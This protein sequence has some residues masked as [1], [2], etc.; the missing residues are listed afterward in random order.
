MVEKEKFDPVEKL[1]TDQTVVF[2]TPLEDEASVYVRTGITKNNSLL[3]SILCA[4]F[5]DYLCMKKSQRKLLVEKTI[6][7]IYNLSKDQWLN[8]DCTLLKKYSTVYLYNIKKSLD[9]KQ[10]DEDVI[11][12]NILENLIISKQICNIFFNIVDIKNL[13]IEINSAKTNLEFKTNFKS[14]INGVLKLCNELKLI[15]SDKTEYIVKQLNNFIDIFLETME[16]LVYSVFLDK[17]KNKIITSDNLTDVSKHFSLNII[18]LDSETRMPNKD[19]YVID[20]K[21]DDYIVL[22]KFEN[23]NTYETLGE[24]L[25]GYITIRTFDNTKDF[26]SKIKNSL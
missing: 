1:T 13:L 21:Y 25:P 15:N 22:I 20:E 14:K 5:S 6:S 10:L 9:D 18:V 26:I 11:N 3:S 4:K 23:T 24:M 8:S 19:E 12:T 2:Y 7:D 17:Y 16:K